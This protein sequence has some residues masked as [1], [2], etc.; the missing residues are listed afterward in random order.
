[1]GDHNMKEWMS[2]EPHVSVVELT[3]D[4]TLLI[5]ACDGVRKMN[6]VLS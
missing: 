6:V 4:D 5:L 2:V 3:P 1:M